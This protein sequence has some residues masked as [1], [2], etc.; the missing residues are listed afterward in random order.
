MPEYSPA[1]DAAE[2]SSKGEPAQIYRSSRSFVIVGVLMALAGKFLEAA[3]EPVLRAAADRI[4]LFGEGV[5][6]E[7]RHEPFRQFLDART[8]LGEPAPFIP[9]EEPEDGTHDAA[10][11]GRRNEDWLQPWSR[12]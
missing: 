3:A 9:I 1:P 6:V 4:D 7:I 5:P 12:D 11:P 2:A 10:H 8:S